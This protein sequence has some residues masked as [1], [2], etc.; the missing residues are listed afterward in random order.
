MKDAKKIS[1]QETYG[2][3]FQHCWGCGPKNDKGLH[4]KSFP[5][6]DKKTVRAKIIPNEM[7]T[8]LLYTSKTIQ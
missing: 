2:E 8:C 6:D 3:R 1:I 7:Y 5:S 4:L